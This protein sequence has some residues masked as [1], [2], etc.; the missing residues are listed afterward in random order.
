MGNN[1]VI[2]KGVTLGRENREKRVG[3]PVIADSMWF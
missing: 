2:H 3:V 1:I